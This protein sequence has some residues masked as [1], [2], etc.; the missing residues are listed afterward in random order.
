MSEVSTV[1]TIRL[2]GNTPK[3]KYRVSEKAQRYLNLLDAARCEGKWE[4]V[5]EL[6][7]KVGKHAPHRKCLVR[8]ARC[9][10]EITG[11]IKRRATSATA[12]SKT[13]SPLL[14]DLH[15]AIESNE[16]S[17]EGV[18]Q[19]RTCLGWLHWILGQ[20]SLALN[21]LPTILPRVT[22][23]STEKRAKISRW[24]QVCM[25]KCACIRGAS[26]EIA[27]NSSDVIDTYTSAL[28]HFRD[29]ALASENGAEYCLWAERL[30]LRCCSLSSQYSKLDTEN[31]GT[32]ADPE[33]ILAPFRA[34]AS[35]WESRPVTGLTT[36]Q[37]LEAGSSAKRRLVWRTYY[38]TLSQLIQYGHNCGDGSDE[39][40]SR[41]PH[42][43]P[44][45]SPRQKLSTELRRIEA[46]YESQLLKEVGFPQANETNSEVVQW[47]D[48]V[49]SN[50]S[51]LCGPMW[52]DEDNGKGGQEGVG[53]NVLE[54]ETHQD[55]EEL[56]LIPTSQILYRAT[57]RTFHST[58]VLRHLFTVHAALGDFELAGK[59][60]D[61]Y[62]EIVMK[63]KARVEK[64]GEPEPDLDS[65]EAMLRTIAA[66]IGIFT[67]YG[68]RTEAGRVQGLAAHLETWSKRHTAKM[69]Q[70]T[71]ASATP[72]KEN[73]SGGSS[74][75][76]PVLAIIHRAI[77]TSQS[78]SARFTFDPA[79]RAELQQKAIESF[80]QGLQIDRAGEEDSETFY[81]LALTLAETRDIESAVATVKL[82][83]SSETASSAATNGH[84][85]YW[86][87][88]AAS[89]AAARRQ[90]KNW[91]L[92]ALL[93]SA[94]QEFET[95]ETFCDA[96]LD[97]SEQTQGITR[98]SSGSRTVRTPL[99]DKK[100]IIEVK[101]TQMAL[102]E[103]NE[104]PDVAV[105]TG[106]ELLALYT[107]F[108]GS[109]EEKSKP[110]PSKSQ[111]PPQTANGTIKSFRGSIFRRSRDPKPGIRTGMNT[112][113]TRSRRTSNEVGGAPTISVTNS[114]EPM[115]E[116]LEPPDSSQP[117]NIYRN[118]SKRLQKR[119]SRKSIRS[120]TV[121]PA[122][123]VGTARSSALSFTGRRP[124]T[125]GSYAKD[126]VGVAVSHDLPTIPTSPA[127]QGDSVSYDFQPLVPF[128]PATGGTHELS[129]RGDESDA[130]PMQL[131]YIP[132]L[133]D[134][135]FSQ[136][137]LQR[138]TL[139]LLLKIWIFIA[140][141]YRRAK[142]YDDAQ[143]A[144]D[145]AF[146]HVK[147]IES[148]VAAQGSSA[149]AFDTPGWGGVKSVEELWADAYAERG[150]LCMARGSP[151]DAIIQ[152]ESALSHF[153][154]HP[155]AT[156]GLATI[157]LDIYTEITSP[158]PT[159]FGIQT[160][161]DLSATQTT[162]D[163]SKPLLES[164]KQTPSSTK[165]DH[166]ASATSPQQPPAL[167]KSS[168]SNQS[169]LPSQN[170]KTPEA[171]DRLAARDRAYGLLSSLTKLGT[172][173]DNSEA[174]FALARAYEESGQLE[175]AKE[176]LWW[177]VELEEKRPI[178]DWSSLGQGY[179]L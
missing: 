128:H 131:M 109:L 85:A 69:Q 74:V 35:F 136:S 169:N 140:G 7:R 25:I 51:V 175:R 60:L 107:R 179:S 178:R 124:N 13:L 76:D 34:W 156:V 56:R 105:N 84:N 72:P 122:R 33:T 172:G 155:A 52:C 114:D 157:L 177:V 117:H 4:E 80:R 19:A 20:P 42:G 30:L 91:H 22:D 83:L 141:L 108:F 24:T 94:R 130:S 62:L 111:S 176:V 32:F 14:P 158:H 171:L 150:N 17:S 152:Y 110:K 81:A 144:V 21:T 88:Q 10:A 11:Q 143:G 63:S 133:I 166:P 118:N 48:Q 27:G 92:L 31:R 87:R 78:H 123:T 55:Y 58:S 146:K 100:H 165:D 73:C 102:T 8:T 138:H 59:A 163:H 37:E 137:E 71:D 18:Y 75:S 121:S 170:R 41:Y 142:M 23:P 125:S 38:D 164:V 95:A 79:S 149:R 154:D 40:K 101:M 98:D 57:T 139:S 119:A 5:P 129:R 65:D 67:T 135:R 145:E 36:N 126:E 61:T 167:D 115:H 44:W 134:P 89:R 148:S 45:V 96:A 127:P 113:S 151:H 132:T 168:L 174:W 2:A 1:G 116:Q 93:L 47:V 70:Q 159:T 77:G 15:S 12:V 106:G 104:G 26:Q 82:A 147:S 120:R 103:V 97:G 86:K 6:A 162:K 90:I 53:R 112:G 99:R 43:E 54:S 66:G 50:W 9:E 160:I 153:P 29:P 16:A 28:S 68:R 39:D 173:W 64:S 49:M 161:S 46:I 3:P